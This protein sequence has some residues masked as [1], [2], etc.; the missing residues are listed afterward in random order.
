[1]KAN[2]KKIPARWIALTSVSAVLV[3]AFSV[4]W[5]VTGQYTNVINQAFNL[6]GS[7]VILTDEDKDKEPLFKSDYSSQE[8]V[9][10]SDKKIAERLTEEGCVLLKNQNSALPLSK[11]ANVTILGHSSTNMLVCGT[12]SADIDATLDVKKYPS[13]LKSANGYLT[14]KDALE[15]RSGVKVNKAV[16]NTYKDWTEKE[17]YKTNPAKGDNSIRG[18]DGS[19]K[20]SYAVN[21]V[22]W[23]TLTSQKGVV[24]SFHDY[25][26][27]AIMVVSRLGGEM[28]D[29]PSSVDSQGNADETVNG[30]GNS[31]ELTIQER[32]V[33]KEAKKQFGKV[34]VLINSA[35]PLE[36]DFLTEENSDVD[37]AMWIGYTGTVGLYGVADL[38]VGNSNPSGRLV[39]TYCN[40]NT[41]NPAMANFY[42]EIWSNAEALGASN[43]PKTGKWKCSG[44]MTGSSGGDLDGNMFFNAYQEGIYV[45][46][47][48]YETR[49]ADMIEGKGN[50]SGYKYLDDVAYPF[51]YGLSYTSFEY[52]N[53]TY[54]SVNDN[55]AIEVSVD[56]T[57]NGSVAGKDVVEVYFQ[58]EYTDYD[59][60]NGIEKAAIELC[61]FD[62][63]DVIEPGKT[64]T[65]KIVVDK[66][67]F[68]TYDRKGAGT[69]IMDEGDYYL[70]IGTDAHDALN[71]V[72]AKKSCSGMYAAGHKTTSTGDGNLVYTWHENAD[73]TTYAKSY[74]S[75]EE[76]Y[77][78]VN[79]FDS[80]ELS[81]YGIEDMPYV[82]RS[83]WTGTMPTSKFQIELNE[84]MRHEMTGMKKYEKVVVEGEEMP[85]MES[86]DTAY[87]LSDMSG[88]DYDDPR[89]DDLLN[90]VSYEEMSNL[91]GV[92]YHG[93]IMVESVAKP[94]THDENGPQ[95]FS[96]KLTDIFGSS[97]TLCAYT[98]EN[99]MAATW[100]VDLMKEVGEHIGEDGLWAGYSG[101]Y[102]PAMN[103]H[104]TAYAGRNF[105]YY[106]EDGF[107]AGKI[108]ASETE[109]I[110]SKGV[111]VFLKHF[112]LNDCETNCR[113]ISTFTNEQAIREVYLQPFEHA[114]VEGGAYN[115]MNAF[116]RV[117]VVWSGAHEGLMTNVLRNE[118][119]CKGFGI[120]DYTTTSYATTEH[121][122][123]TYDGLLGVLAGTDTFDSSS[124]TTQAYQ[125][126]AYNAADPSVN[127]VHL[128]LAMR[129]AAHRIFYTVANSNAMNV[130]GIYVPKLNWWQFTIIDGIIYSSIA[131][132]VFGALTIIGFIKAPKKEPD[133]EVDPSI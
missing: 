9:K 73:F 115:V 10:E 47:R 32:E 29:L 11:N 101:L 17:T 94:E 57:N 122:R 35:N 44:L 88:L 128:V 8:E 61:G 63:T 112:A 71:N 120:S 74:E 24:E 133:L 62:K 54:K 131:T 13:A 78:I 97:V 42:S 105:E 76:G 6:S 113:S 93:T 60:A 87:K 22:P 37:A 66:S 36:C 70:T 99:I 79:Q 52:S 18:G 119:G 83:N 30:S 117:G 19:V 43:D 100:N 95:G 53:V 41:T 102:G 130:Q 104:R 123:G 89:W 106:S 124:T 64:E 72:L 85:K 12:G 96:A 26:D 39:D 20:G 125:L 48:Y 23:A 45:G 56:V 90:Q 65:V 121:A 49:Y 114:V 1:M 75:S 40:D 109:G 33:I 127:D 118:W 69:Y 77:D 5:A 51:G 58:S 91:I 129:Q 107:L 31:L 110:Q 34:I 21:E 92:G 27:A 103:T 28:Y 126:L 3:A 4:G 81:T 16:W 86:K 111:Y 15:E 132:L 14:I 2:K 67:E 84:K 68:R 55:K 7:K 38:L 116:A 25:N 80:A 82:S 98:D 50:T 46:Y 59:K 108:A